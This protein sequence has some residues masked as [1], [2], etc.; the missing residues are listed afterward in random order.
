MNLYQLYSRIYIAEY[1]IAEF[2]QNE[3]IAIALAI[4]LCSSIA[5]QPKT[6]TPTS[7]S[8][9]PPTKANR[10]LGMIKKSK[11]LDL[12]M[13]FKLFTTLV[14]PIFEYSN[15]IWRPPFTL[16]QRKVEKVQCRATHLLP[17]LHDESYTERLSLLS[18]PSLLY[19]RQRGDLMFL[20]RNL[21][22]YF[23]SDFTNLYTY[24]TTILPSGST[25][26]IV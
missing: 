2:L 12:G 25:S 3:F 8:L 26:L 4:I 18:L 7:S 19:R 14:R 10:I 11:Y 15:A 22:Y 23:S 20:Y 17:S 16:D 6:Y 13:L 21:N 9:P 1:Y 5:M 24:S